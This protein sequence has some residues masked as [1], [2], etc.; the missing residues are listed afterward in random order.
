MP[1]GG[2]RKNSG[3]PPSVLTRTSRDDA[4]AATK[5]VNLKPIDVMAENMRFWYDASVGLTKKITDV[6]SMPDVGRAFIEDH[7]LLRELNTNLKNMLFARAQSQE[8]AV[9]MAPYR[10]P[11]LANI[12]VHA[13]FGEDDVPKV[14]QITKKT[15]LKE[16]AR[17]YEDLLRQ[18][19]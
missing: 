11:R 16:A 10:H 15:D 6:L 7:E 2:P 13:G 8:C 14:P 5:A 17:R 19:V 9:D 1:K 18:G 3:R 12:E 4:L